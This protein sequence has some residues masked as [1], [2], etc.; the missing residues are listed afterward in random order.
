MT[1]QG[2]IDELMNL[3][4]AD[5][6]PIYY[7][8]SIEKVI[9]T[10]ILE[11]A[12][13][14]AIVAY[15]DEPNNRN[16]EPITHD[17]YIESGNDYLEA[18]CLNC[19]NAKACKEKHWSGCIYKPIEDE[20]QTCG[21]CYYYSDVGVKCC[22][23]EHDPTTPTTEAC[24]MYEPKDEPQTDR[25]SHDCIGCGRNELCRFA[26]TDAVKICR[27]IKDEPQT[28][29]VNGRPYDCG[30]CEYFRCTADEPQTERSE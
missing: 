26:F 11:R 2:A 1:I 8:P 20:P 12:R 4:D 10:I 6:V 15:I 7:K 14:K 3:L 22:D 13:R 28:C 16:T 23:L 18:R 9:D 30:N 19:N 27:Y 25:W 17:D 21:N 29:S 24:E 5:D